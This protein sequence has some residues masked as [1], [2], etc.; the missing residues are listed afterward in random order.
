VG[1]AV[2]LPLT[3]LLRSL[4]FGVTATDPAT[5]L[6]VSAGLLVA[7]ALACYLPANRAVRTDPVEALRFD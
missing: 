7:G 4:L 3:R 5:F 1:I 6:A 2:A